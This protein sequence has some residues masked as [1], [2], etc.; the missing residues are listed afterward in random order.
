MENHDLAI[1]IPRAGKEALYR[2][3]S[4]L[5][6]QSDKRFAVYG[7]FLRDDPVMQA[8][9]DDYA[10][11]LD[12]VECPV[13]AFPGAD[14]GLGEGISFYLDR[15]G[16]EKFVT[17]SDGYCLYDRDAVQAFHDA[18]WKAGGVDL[19]CWRVQRRG[20]RFCPFRRF[21]RAEILGRPWGLPGGA[22]VLR[23]TSLEG[24]VVPA[25]FF[26]RSQVLTELASQGGILRLDARVSPWQTPPQP[27]VSRQ[28]RQQER[29]SLVEWAEARFPDMQWPVGIL[30]SLSRTADLFSDLAPET[31]VP[32]IRERFMAL[33]MAERSPFLAKAFFFQSSRGL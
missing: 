3:L 33:K 21:F 28:D 5:T 6:L 23:R 11:S 9:Y 18:A 7:F 20:S 26:S 17:F 29:C 1:I 30:R 19:F 16:G 13:D 12:L 31:P 32:Q 24:Q 22:W 10:D 15:I 8:L 14:A 2:I 4:S 27:E 25:D